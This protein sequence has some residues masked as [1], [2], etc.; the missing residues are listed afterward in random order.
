MSSEE[1]TIKDSRGG[2]NY[3]F[4]R[5][6]VEAALGGLSAQ[7]GMTLKKEAVIAR[8]QEL[9]A[10]EVER[11][12]AVKSIK[13]RSLT[14]ALERALAAI[15]AGDEEIDKDWPLPRTYGSR[16]YEVF[17]RP[18]TKE[19]KAILGKPQ[20]HSVEQIDADL[21]LLNMLAEDVVIIPRGDRLSRYLPSTL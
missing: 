17:L 10:E 15:E 8:L 9:R 13:E 7:P 16:T 6:D 1:V 3:Y 12:E 20:R 19:E 21:A 4:V 14:E 18:Y 2:G 11:A 5:S